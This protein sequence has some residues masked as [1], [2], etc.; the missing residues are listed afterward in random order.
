MSDVISIA[1]AVQERA[2]QVI[3][4]TRVVDIWQSVGATINLVGSLKTGL[5]INKRDID[6]HIYTDPFRLADSFSAVARLAENGRI[7]R[8]YSQIVGID[9]YRA[10]LEGGVHDLEGFR[11]WKEEHPDTGIV[12]WM[13]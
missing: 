4:E 6:F 1:E 12:E 2:W 10:V 9:V 8:V 7:K 11:S 3:E 13:P 5:L